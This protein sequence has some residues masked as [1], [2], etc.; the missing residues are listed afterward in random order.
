MQDKTE[1]GF[2]EQRLRSITA[3]SP[4]LLLDCPASE[5][6]RRAIFN[7]TFSFFDLWPRPWRA[8]DRWVSAFPSLGNGQVASRPPPIHRY[9]DHANTY[10]LLYRANSFAR[11][12]TRICSV[13]SFAVNSLNWNNT[14]KPYKNKN[15]EHNG[16]TLIQLLMISL[17]LKCLLKCS[18]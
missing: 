13:R 11:L 5:P 3:G 10:L 17:V 6:V 2:F 18:L 7:P 16:E 1:G 12:L 8:P 9:I 15:K 4:H 14:M